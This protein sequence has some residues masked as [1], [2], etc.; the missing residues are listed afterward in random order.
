M[1]LCTM[2]RP[3]GQHASN[4]H[5]SARA[6]QT[7]WVDV[8]HGMHTWSLVCHRTICVWIWW[9]LLKSVST[10]GHYYF[11][12]YCVGLLVTLKYS[13]IDLHFLHLQ[14][15]FSVHFIVDT[16]VYE[17]F[18]VFIATSYWCSDNGMLFSCVVDCSW[19]LCIWI[20]LSRLNWWSCP[21]WS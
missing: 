11:M 8:R 4:S 18:D 3:T 10:N 7:G 16:G 5:P 15:Q 13:I 21:P 14:A 2:A 1:C 9:F 6:R 20:G 17:L 12:Q 19:W